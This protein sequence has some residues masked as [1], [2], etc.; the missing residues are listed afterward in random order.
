M[1]VMSGINLGWICLDDLEGVG[2]KGRTRA[3]QI[4]HII[5][6]FLPTLS[7]PCVCDIMTLPSLLLS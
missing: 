5:K 1:L 3:I 2:G 4:N 7:L 6:S